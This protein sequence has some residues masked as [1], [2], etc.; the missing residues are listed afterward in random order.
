MG[1]LLRE[2]C[3]CSSGNDRGLIK[4]EWVALMEACLTDCSG[5]EKSSSSEQKTFG[6]DVDDGVQADI[7][8]L[9]GGFLGEAR[10]LITF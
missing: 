4:E 7:F 1:V 9:S 8:F 5:G 10:S 3:F 2:P 6:L